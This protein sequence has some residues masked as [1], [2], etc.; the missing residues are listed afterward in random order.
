[1]DF[2][3]LDL[4]LLLVLDAMLEDCSTV[5]VARRLGTSQPT[6]SASL[7]KLRRFFGDELFVRRGTTMEPTPLART[8]LS[9]VRRIVDTVRTELFSEGDFDPATTRRC[10]TF[11]TS[12]IGELVFIPD[13]MRAAAYEAPGATFQCLAKSPDELKGMM[14]TGQ[15]DVAMGYF[16][17]IGG[18]GF[19]EQR[20]FEHPFACLVRRDHPTVGDKLTLDQFLALDHMVV[21]QAGRSQEVFEQRMTQLALRRRVILRSPHFM[22]VP[23]LLAETDAIV[24]VPQALARIFADRAHLKVLPIPVETPAIVLK[25]F[26][27]RCVHK[28][29]AVV[30][31]RQLIVRLFMNKDPTLALDFP[32]FARSLP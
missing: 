2:R 10:F 15:I 23:L 1:M 29:P 25:L 17:D 27:H 5:A 8:L 11:S 28:D 12:D 6:V 30:W 4:N 31:L 9:P 7:A 21:E 24:T 22:C 16:P 13:L 20:L 14:A 32:L 19:Y 26:W 3:G 18:A